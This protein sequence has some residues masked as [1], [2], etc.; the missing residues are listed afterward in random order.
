[1][2]LGVSVLAACGP[3]RRAP[4]V[5]AAAGD[6]ASGE[7]L[8][9]RH[10][11][12]CDGRTD[13]SA[14]LQRVLDAARRPGG[15]GRRIIL[16][17]GICVVSRTL[18]VRGVVG[19]S[20]RGQGPVVTELEWRGD[21]GSP[22]L[23]LDRTLLA[24]LEGFSVTVGKHRQLEVAVRIEQGPGCVAQDGP[25]C[26]DWPSSSATL[27]DVI[28]RGRGRLRNGVHVHLVEPTQDVRND[29]HGFQRVQV[30][31]FTGAAFVLEGRNAKSLTFIACQC[32]GNDVGRSCIDT[33]PVPRHGASFWWYG[34]VAVG[35]TIADFDIGDRNDT[36]LLSG[37]YS[38]KSARFL[39][40]RDPSS[41]RRH[42]FPVVVEAVRFAT[43][44]RTAADGEVVQFVGRG[45]LTIIGS[46]WGVEGDLG[47]DVHF[48]VDLGSEA[49]D[50]NSFVFTGNYVT[51]SGAEL[52]PGQAPATAAGNVLLLNRPVTPLRPPR[53]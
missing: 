11:V 20:L 53:R 6:G 23:R 22:L 4:I 10:G 15:I 40:V 45:P 39:R 7:I 28:V 31:G 25:T 43:G 42:A 18:V 46:R 32:K 19:M 26:T 33:T 48:R 9:L 50:E 34:G 8:A 12:R 37:V 29:M 36:L 2:A 14:A 47:R 16:P 52:F 17:P 24:T 21:G 3:D 49:G 44:D 30:A 51:S 5:P 38:E 41:E 13:D 27:R 35:H 1:M